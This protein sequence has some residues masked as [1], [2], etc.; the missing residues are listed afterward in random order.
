MRMP[1]LL[2]ALLVASAIAGSQVLAAALDPAL[3]AVDAG[4]PVPALVRVSDSQVVADAPSAPGQGFG[5]RVAAQVE[6][7]KARATSSQQGL[8][9]ELHARGIPH[10]A[11][12]VA[13]VVSVQA[14]PAQLASLAARADVAA[15][16]ADRTSVLDL[17]L[18]EP[19]A[20]RAEAI[21]WG[22][23]R[24][25]APEAWALGYRGQGVVIGGQD[26]GYDW[27]HPALR[28]RYR[29]W[30][31]SSANH[32]HN[33]HDA[34]V[35]GPA[36]DCGLA[37]A[38]PCDDN[39]HGTHT[40]GTVLGDDGGTNQIGVAPGARWIG[41]R[42][43]NNGAGTQ[44]TYLDCFQWFLAPTDVDGDDP[45]PELAPH[46]LVNSWGC[47]EFE[48]CTDDSV[49]GEAVANVHAA[50]ILVVASAGNAGPGCAT[51]LDPP[52]IY[53]QT[54]SIGATGMNDAITSFSSR[55]PA[56]GGTLKPDLAAPGASIRSSLRNGAYGSFSGTSMAAPHVAGI[57][58]LMI[59]ADTSLAGDPDRLAALLRATAIPATSAQSCGAFPGSVVPNA[60]FGHGRVD[61]LAA[62]LEALGAPLFADG[63]EAP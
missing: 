26:T 31:G 19:V 17:P 15:V 62:V 33:W 47:P 23:A 4:Q 9:A 14:T 12:W 37:S 51:I 45:R 59:S 49:L 13:N 42:N 20:K 61:A 39:N 6:R 5:Q 36:N 34:I 50:G 55:G 53:P 24:V 40:M 8:L 54:L 16:Q 60:V 30:T 41:C 28:D 18:E 58:A 22:V 57:A 48:G 2:A 25:R 11:F 7:L 1:L 44:S 43:M 21:E 56:P 27:D 29:G 38:E 32:D 46:V 3:L 35:A 52:A 10:R 63:F